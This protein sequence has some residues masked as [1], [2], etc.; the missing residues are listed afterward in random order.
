[1]SSLVR[2][3]CAAAALVL[4]AADARAELELR[5]ADESVLDLAAPEAPL[6]RRR[7]PV[8]FVHGHNELSPKDS[9]LRYRTDWIVSQP[10]LTS[11]QEALKLP[12]NAWL[13]LEPYFIRF[14]DQNRSIV[15]DA[16]EIAEAVEVILARH[17]RDYDPTAPETWV[18]SKLAVVA[19]GKGALSTRLYLKNLHAAEA[20][21]TGFNPIS[22]FVAIA[23]PNHGLASSSPAL[24]SLSRR[25]LNNGYRADCTPYGMLGVSDEQSLGFI[26]E[27]NGHPIED[28]LRPADDPE[29][30]PGSFPQEA[31]GSRRNG[32]AVTAGTLYVALY[33]DGGRDRAG[34][35]RPSSDCMG[36]VL[37][38]NLAPHAVNI[39]VPQVPDEPTHGFSDTRRVVHENTPHTTE[40]VCQAL[41][42]IAFHRTPGP[43]HPCAAV[44]SV[45][46]V[47]PRTA[48][49]LLLDTSGSMRART[50]PEGPSRLEVARDAAELFVQLFALAADS[51]DRLGVTTFGSV[52]ASLDVGGEVLPPIGRDNVRFL[53]DHVSRLVAAP[54]ARSSL[55]G[56]LQVALEALRDP[57]VSVV[58]GRH[59]VLFTDGMQSASPV[60][61]SQPP[62]QEGAP[63]KLVIQRAED[64]LD[65]GVRA[66][67][68]A[69]EVAR[70]AGI[71]VHTLG[72]SASNA[73]LQPLVAA[74][75]A[76]D[77]ASRVTL[78]PAESLSRFAVQ[79]L[80]EVLG[81]RGPRWVAERRSDGP[82]E[83]LEPFTLGAGARRAFFVLT[84]ERGHEVGFSLLKD[85]RD[86]TGC[87]TLVRG[88]YY[89]IAALDLPVACDGEILSGDGE[90]SLEVEGDA[91][92]HR[93]LLLV[94]DPRVGVKV[95]LA[96]ELR[97]GD[98]LDV[99]VQVAVEGRPL[100]G[101]DVKVTV[102]APEES[103]GNLLSL[104]SGLEAPSALAAELEAPS[105]RNAVAVAAD[106]ELWN[107][108]VPRA[109][110][111][112]TSLE[113]PGVHVARFEGTRTSGPYTVRVD[114][115]ASDPV[116]GSL[117]RSVERT[118][119]VRFGTLVRERSRLQVIEL[120]QT[121]KGR[122]LRLSLRPMDR[123]G[124][125]LGPDHG[126]EI[127]VTLASGRV[128]TAPED[129]SDGTYR[130]P[131]EVGFDADPQ[132]AI[133]VSGKLAYDGLLSG[134]QVKL[135]DLG[136]W[137]ILVLILLVAI[138]G[139][140][141]F[142][143][144][145]VGAGTAH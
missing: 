57:V 91:T 77:G 118:C 69:T 123:F 32:A 100:A 56:G 83:R 42:A 119:L 38:K 34:G 82:G 105:Q 107:R 55:G 41:A 62:A 52:V 87:A 29:W 72:F 37:A 64:L 71:H 15:E 89:Q 140:I 31:P 106:A 90:W 116:L 60:L 58:P 18:R 88:D 19:V 67:E 21:R 68:P 46:V 99:R 43:D 53:R 109:V 6:P 117:R 36:R 93:A 44:G 1:M 66:T 51:G 143:L 9:D 59:V 35:S 124:N 45:P 16:A 135:E 33:A 125:L 28:T 141:V 23:P 96:P 98:P 5:L 70:T 76:T 84:W 54:T 8:L 24:I 10:G 11:F 40:V 12:E 132:V 130:I 2:T 134:L 4:A 75:S 50:S 22:E 97:V 14:E 111:L 94:Q 144:F 86:V 7:F 95:D 49:M 78:Q 112:V 17:Y 126:R 113:A 20:L 73:Y 3:L 120:D 102:L 80:A 103:L 39:A 48:A 145:Q 63:R 27:L 25:Q 104:H 122:L 13:D 74:A 114:V 26:A 128:L 131:L 110:P 121:R 136:A 129:V 127:E 79:A 133:R 30:I 65:S 101:V 92:P 137:W 142:A 47:V 61:A 85:G 138:V 108:L 115:T 81:D 139:L